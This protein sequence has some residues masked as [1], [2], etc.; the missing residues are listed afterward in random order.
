[1]KYL[2]EAS[3]FRPPVCEYI[4]AQPSFGAHLN[5]KVSNSY[6]ARVIAAISLPAWGGTEQNKAVTKWILTSDLSYNSLDADLR[7]PGNMPNIN[8]AFQGVNAFPSTIRSICQLIRSMHPQ[9]NVAAFKN[10]PRELRRLSADNVAVND[11]FLSTTASHPFRI[12]FH[13]S[14]PLIKAHQIRY[15]VWLDFRLLADPLL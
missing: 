5:I 9:L 11:P 3:S 15:N 10:V 13:P 14:L 12:K 6:I 2:G 1:M 4:I 7:F 8:T